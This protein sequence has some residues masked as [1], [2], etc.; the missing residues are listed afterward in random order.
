MFM[1]QGCL[2]RSQHLTGPFSH[3]RGRRP[4]GTDFRQPALGAQ[5]GRGCDG[6][7]PATSEV[8]RCDNTWERTVMSTARA[9]S[10]VNTFDSIY[11]IQT[12]IH[13][14]GGVGVSNKEKDIR[15]QNIWKPLLLN[16]LQNK[17]TNQALSL[18]WFSSPKL[19]F[20]VNYF[21]P[22]GVTTLF[23]NPVPFYS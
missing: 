22:E 8:C 12:K 9:N 4:T 6:R 15:G 23:N 7:P 21:I 19:T 3:L 13:Q 10:F 16:A 11:V 2:H 17:D 14:D 5:A 1:Q 20:E 18:L